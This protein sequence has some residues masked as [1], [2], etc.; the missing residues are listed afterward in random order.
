MIELGIWETSRTPF[1]RSSTKSSLSRS[2]S[3][4]VRG[5]MG[6]DFAHRYAEGHPGERYY[7]G[8]EIIDEIDLVDEDDE[9]GDADLACQQDVFA[10]LRHWAFGRV[11][12]Q[13]HAIDHVHDA[14]HLPAEVGMPWGVQDVDLAVPPRHVGERGVHGDLAG[15]LLL[16]DLL[17]RQ[18]GERAGRGEQLARKL[19]QGRRMSWTTVVRSAHFDDLILHLVRLGVDNIV[20]LA[21]GLDARPYRLALLYFHSILLPQLRRFSNATA[22]EIA[23]MTDEI[24]QSTSLAVAEV[25]S[26]V[27]KVK[28]GAEL[29]EKAGGAMPIF[30]LQRRTLDLGA[31]ALRRGDRLEPGDTSADHENSSRRH[32]AGGSHHHREAALERADQRQRIPIGVDEIDRVVGRQVVGAA[33]FE[34][35]VRRGMTRAERIAAQRSA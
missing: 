1:F 15:D 12:E 33:D 5:V 2:Q 20:N 29:T 32:R 27:G 26:T 7:Q 28:S 35:Q 16:G 17:A 21:A 6:S 22:R 9:I 18:L 3:A 11:D 30:G 31:Q 34:M 4:R 10:R 13:Q 24:R 14:L 19:P 25:N 8:T 23:S